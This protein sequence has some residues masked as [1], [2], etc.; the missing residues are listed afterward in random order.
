SDPDTGEKD[1]SWEETEWTE[2]GWTLI[3][4]VEGE[5]INV[6]P[7]GFFPKGLPEELYGWSDK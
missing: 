7:D 1:Y 5:F 6:P 2:T 4:R 3:R